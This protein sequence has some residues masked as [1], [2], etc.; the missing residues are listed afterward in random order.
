MC[1]EKSQSNC[2][3]SSADTV[4]DS[5]RS[6]ICLSSI[7]WSIGTICCKVA[8]VVRTV[9]VAI[10][11]MSSLYAV[12]CELFL[13]TTKSVVVSLLMVI[14]DVEVWNASGCIIVANVDADVSWLDVSVSKEQDQTETRLGENIKDTV[15]DSFGITRD[16]VSTL[17]ETPG[18]WVEEPQGHCPSSSIHVSLAD[19]GI[20]A[21]PDLFCMSLSDEGNVVTDKE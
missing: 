16:D 18:N 6:R 7:C 9:G 19:V 21:C 3:D 14:R 10:A 8:I 13:S 1:D 20:V 5:C 2:L 12:T 4:I 11:S 15:E 17:G